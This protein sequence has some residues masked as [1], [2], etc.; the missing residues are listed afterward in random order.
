VGREVVLFTGKKPPLLGTAI[1]DYL[2]TLGKMAQS[3]EEPMINLVA[4][5]EDGAYTVLIFPRQKHRP[6]VFFKEGDDRIVVSP[7]VVEMAGIIV[8]PFCKDFE[9]LDAATIEAIHSE[10]TFVREKEPT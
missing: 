9:R 10:V 3:A 2:G 8:T 6:D 7:A 4:C 5:F 1:I